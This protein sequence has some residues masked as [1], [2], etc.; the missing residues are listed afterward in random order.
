MLEPAMH[1]RM[2]EAVPQ[3]GQPF[4]VQQLE[5]DCTFQSKYVHGRNCFLKVII[6]RW[7][8]P[9]SPASQ[10]IP[11]SIPTVWP[12]PP[13]VFLQKNS[14]LS[15]M[16]EY[17]FHRDGLPPPNGGGGLGKRNRLFWVAK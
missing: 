1:K 2:K 3:Q 5:D 14:Q 16:P 6:I 17:R 12:V 13:L 15:K 4:Q 8:T 7:R 10:Y 11:Y 9:K